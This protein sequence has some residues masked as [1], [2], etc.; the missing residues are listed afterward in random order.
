[1][2]TLSAAL[3]LDRMSAR[4]SDQDWLAARLAAPSTRFM[5]LVALKPAI[6]SND[7]RTHSAIRWFAQ[8]EMVE[9]GL[10][11]HD[12]YFLGLDE[13]ERAHFALAITEHRARQVPG[14]PEV[15][16]PLVDLRTLAM[17][18]GMARDEL[19]LIGEARALAHWHVNSR[20][21]GHCGGVTRIKDGGWRRRC[22]ACGTEVF[23]RMDPVVIMLVRDPSGERCLLGREH[24]FPE[25]FY[26]ALAGYLEPGEAIED[27]VRREVQEETGVRV[28]TVTYRASQP[29]P[30]PHTLMIGCEA[31]A[32]TDAITIEESELADARW[33]SREEARAMLE[34]RHPEGLTVPGP[35]AIAHVLIRT[36][37]ER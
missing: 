20:C 17:Q 15:L 29:W 7:E 26:S 30:F 23:P 1:M 3:Q 11:A 35:Y 31:E 24:R 6:V 2:P 21:C 33:V 8:Q 12:A 5:L 13:E 28:G 22:W 16:K 32:E 37:A 36:F 34:G 18:G 4:R 10:D 9:L 27:A 25:G 14:G 19:A